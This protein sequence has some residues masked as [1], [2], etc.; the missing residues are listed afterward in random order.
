MAVYAVGD[1][2]GCFQAFQT[3]LEK[4]NFSAKKD[5]LWLAGDLVNRGPDSLAVLRFAANNPSCQIVLG[6]H[7]L[8][9]LALYYLNKAP[10]KKDTLDDVIKAPD[11][12]ELLAWLTEQPLCLHHKK[13]NFCM[14]HAGIP[15]IWSLD[16]ALSYSEEVSSVLSS[17]KRTKLLQGLYGNEPSTWSHALSGI[18]R[19][20]LIINYLTRMRFISATGKLNLNHKEAPTA[21]PTGYQPWFEFDHPITT[22]NQIVFGHWAAT[23]GKTNQPHIHGLDTGCVWGNALTAMRL[24]DNKRYSINCT[25]NKTATPRKKQ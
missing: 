5:R 14:A 8:H 12:P 19:W 10:R 4:I 23:L 24:E 21:T 25:S 9:L 22:N 3:L 20:R 15:A 11:A 18:D 17:K 7:D 16:Q 13:L 6:N 1:I 2:Q